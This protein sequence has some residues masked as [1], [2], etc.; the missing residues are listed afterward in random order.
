MA[1]IRLVANIHVGSGDYSNADEPSCC[2]IPGSTGFASAYFGVDMYVGVAVTD[3]GELYVSVN[4]GSVGHTGRQLTKAT[5]PWTVY[6]GCSRS[7]FTIESVGE[8]PQGG[9]MM[10]DMSVSPDPGSNCNA[11]YDFSPA[12]PSVEAGYDSSML[13][14]S[15]HHFANV[16]DLETDHKTYF[17]FHVAFPVKNTLGEENFKEMS[18]VPIRVDDDWVPQIF[19]YFPWGRLIDGEWWSHNRNGGKLSRYNSKWADVKNIQGDSSKSKGFRHDGTQWNMSPK[20]GKE[21]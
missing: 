17:M 9:W 3:E 10:G 15:W 4:G 13:S 2:Y 19:E 18:S 1:T 11:N 21:V 8:L 7:A 16:K 5:P 6:W 14:G 20:T 12:S